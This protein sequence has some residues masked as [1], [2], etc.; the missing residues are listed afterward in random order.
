MTDP[1]M[2]I[3]RFFED[4]ESM[5]QPELDGLSE[6]IKQDRAHAKSFAQAAFIHRAIY[7]SLTSE[8][9]QQALTEPVSSP[10][11]D[12]E[13]FRWDDHFW[14]WVAEY[15]KTAPAMALDEPGP[16]E[17]QPRKAETAKSTRRANRT[18]LL[19]SAF[20]ATAVVL[21]CVVGEIGQH[22][23]PSE[24]ATLRNSMQV[25]WTGPTSPE[26]GDRLTRGKE[27][28][29]L[30]QGMV[31]VAFDSG[32]EAVIE[33]PAQ[34]RLKSAN[35]IELRSGRLFANVSEAARGFT[36][37]TPCGRIVDL[38]TQ[39]GVEVDSDNS[40]DLYLFK[41]KAALTPARAEGSG[42]SEI[43]AAGQAGSVNT[44]GRIAS[45]PVDGATFVRRFFSTS[46]FVW[47]GRP[48]DLA[49]VVGGGNGAGTGQL[50]RWL[51]IN[52]GL[53]GTRFIVNGQRTQ[54]CQAT[55]NRYHR[56]THLPYVDGV[57]APDGSAGPVQVSSQGHLWRDC[58]KTSGQSFED[59]FNGDYISFGTDSHGL[60]LQG[61]AYGTRE[62]P[63]LA[64][65]SNAGITF[66]LDALRRDMPGLKITRFTARCGITEDVRT[67][68]ANGM[69]WG[70]ADFWVLV[71]GEKRFEAK[72][73]TVDSAPPEIS[74]PLGEQERFVTL[75][76]TDGDGGANFDWGF[77]AEPRLD[78]QVAQ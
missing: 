45:I 63:A 70:R 25:K 56:V 75:V 57:F 67:H 38:G 16:G 26:S 78:V 22:W 4:P 17:E 41:G 29:R 21:F 44:A 59:I 46:G 69:P 65:H 31:D 66:D 19:A 20:C 18:W 62:H 28:L 71:D 64:L 34:F 23:F 74:V 13:E 36:V 39:F 54:N 43:L 35:R 61:Q 51:G 73:I 1:E 3:S 5:T 68:L 72:G 15:E 40:S 6:W 14:R 42:A 7:D 53:D 2:L 55:D 47:R 50:N 33:G 58:P 48:I 9:T 37:D 27:P 52:T 12:D 10:L 76:T 30:A 32:A 11:A 8:Q 60:V 49:D 24:V 77:F